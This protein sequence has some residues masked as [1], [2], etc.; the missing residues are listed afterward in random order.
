M[1]GAFIGKASLKLKNSLFKG[2]E[3]GHDA[4]ARAEPICAL[5]LKKPLGLSRLAKRGYRGGTPAQVGWGDDFMKTPP[6]CLSDRG[7][8]H[9]KNT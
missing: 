8:N 9:A 1:V 7:L 6:I 5:P 4:Q 2:S 3:P